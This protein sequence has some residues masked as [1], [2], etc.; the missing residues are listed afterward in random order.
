MTLDEDRC[1]ALLVGARHGVLATLHPRRGVDAVPVVYVCVGRSI[2]IPV[3]RVKP[4]Q[5]RRLQRL[6]NIGSDDRCVLLVDHYEDDW[7]KLWWVRVH[8]QATTA[9]TGAAGPEGD[10]IARALGERFAPYSAPGSIDSI[11]T[12]RPTE[13]L[14]WAAE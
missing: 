4:K 11:I 2:V 9:T 3:D 10:D 1:W 8:A 6:A 7:Y 12:L 5:G 13:I 14:G